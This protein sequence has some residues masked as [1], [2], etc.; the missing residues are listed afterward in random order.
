MNKPGNKSKMAALTKGSLL[1][2]V[3]QVLQTSV[4]TKLYKNETPPP[5]HQVWPE[6]PKSPDQMAERAPP[7]HAVWRVKS[8]IRQPYWIKDLVKEMKL[9]QMRKMYVF[10]N[11]PSVNNKLWQIKHLIRIVPVNLKNGVPRP[12]EYDGCYLK[13]NGELVIRKRLEP[14]VELPQLSEGETE[15]IHQTKPMIGRPRDG[16][17]HTYEVKLGDYSTLAEERRSDEGEI[18]KMS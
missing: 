12:E 10:R 5:P 4:R 2:N 18:F 14:L 1:R 13:S 17:G 6:F 7:L 15:E 11:T 16:H 3:T 9:D 8:T